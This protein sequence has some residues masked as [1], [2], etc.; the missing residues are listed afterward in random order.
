MMGIG[1]GNQ[2]YEETG[3]MKIRGNWNEEKLVITQ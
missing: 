3:S 2:T 1:D